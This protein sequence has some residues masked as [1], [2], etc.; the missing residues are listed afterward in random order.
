MY[1]YNLHVATYGLTDKDVALLQA[2]KE[3]G[4][5]RTT[6]TQSSRLNLEL[7]LKSDIL[8]CAGKLTDFMLSLLRQTQKSCYVILIVDEKLL[9]AE[10]DKLALAATALWPSHITAETQQKLFAQV[11]KTVRTQRQASIVS[12][13]LDSLFED[14]PDM[15]WFKDRSGVRLKVNTR[16][17]EVVGKSKA[18][19]EGKKDDYIWNLTKEEYE[20]GEYDCA[21]T[22][23]LVIKQNKPVMFAEKLRYADNKVHYQ[24]TY[25]APVFS[26]SGEVL[27]T[28]GFAKDITDVWNSKS[29]VRLILNNLPLAILILDQNDNIKVANKAF[30]RT[31]NVKAE[32]VEK[33]TNAQHVALYKASRRVLE[34]HQDGDGC[35][36]IFERIINGKK[37]IFNCLRHPLLNK[38]GEVSGATLIFEDITQEREAMLSSYKKTVT[39]SLT[40]VFNRHYYREIVEQLVKN[41]RN[42]AMIMLDLDDLKY[43]N[44]N[45]GHDSGDKYIITVA[46]ILQTHLEKNDVLCRIGGDE[47]VAFLATGEEK[48]ARAIMEQ[49]NQNLQEEGLAFPASISYGVT[50]LQAPDFEK[51]RQSAAYVDKQMYEMKNEKKQAKMSTGEEV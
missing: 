21:A 13:Y 49:V 46:R 42:F 30:C 50:A 27:G 23:A 48:V 37:Y 41:K 14:I 32:D 17:C 28:V 20:T 3:A 29:E 11:L 47:F 1:Y 39:D 51:F 40:G 35:S 45:F 25:K 16:F 34:K 4:P 22:D 33:R 19:I 6:F 10:A 5:L 26:P 8:V 44:D 2:V 9:M 38:L 15:V 7:L 12:C 18:D 24:N 31:F 43:V 36:S